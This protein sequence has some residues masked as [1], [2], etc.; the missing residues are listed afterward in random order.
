MAPASPHLL[1]SDDNSTFNGWLG[2]M[3]KPFISEKIA[4][5][6]KKKTENSNELTTA[7]RMAE[8]I[9]LTTDQ[10][11]YLK[12]LAKTIVKFGG[13]TSLEL[14]P[15]TITSPLPS[16]PHQPPEYGITGVTSAVELPAPPADK[17]PMEY[18]IMREYY[19]YDMASSVQKGPYES[20]FEACWRGDNRQ[21]E[22]LC[23]PPKSGKKPK[24]AVYLQI[25]AEARPL[26]NA[27]PKGFEFPYEM[28]V[29]YSG[30]VYFRCKRSLFTSYFRLHS[31]GSRNPG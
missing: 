19:G 7:E 17:V 1:W 29:V 21:I 4:E 8:L 9:R 14:Y 30:M 2:S 25:T 24:D 27:T 10:W 20:L 15:P 6:E 31:F 26:F 28:N 22:K 16:P 13:K 11:E 23:L 18:R 5:R 12:E 3:F